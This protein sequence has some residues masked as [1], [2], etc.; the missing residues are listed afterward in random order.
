MSIDILLVV[1]I[2]FTAIITVLQRSLLKGAIGLALTSALLTIQ[3]FRF[4]SPLAAVFELSI[5]AGLITVVFISTI[6]LAEPLSYQD[7]SKKLKGR[8]K[9]YL[10]LPVLLVALIALILLIPN[11]V[12]TST[13]MLK[14]TAATT[15][16]GGNSDVRNILWNQ[17]GMD[18]LGQ[19]VI[20]LTGVFGV[21]LLF[22]ERK[23]DE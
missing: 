8:Y 3:L 14:S 6:S 9:K 18:I 2:V 11:D 20:M 17:Q 23:N 21:V 10:T 12:L 7:L 5:C 1:T 13:L 19:I 22:K 15:T 4:S 16:T